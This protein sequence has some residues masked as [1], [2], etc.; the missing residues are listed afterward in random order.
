MKLARALL[1][2][3]VT[4]IGSLPIPAQTLWQDTTFGMPI[5]AV[6]LAVPGAESPQGKPNTLNGGAVEL[7]RLDNVSILSRRW[8]ASFFFLDSK[9]VQVNLTTDD[10]SLQKDTIGFVYR[11][12]LDTLR[13]KYGRELSARNDRGLGIDQASASW[14]SNGTNINA[15]LFASPNYSS[16]NIAYQVRM[17]KDAGKL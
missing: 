2:A 15:S 4:L 12:L 9:L 8:A 17:S 11:D 5:D 3:T 7:L 6:R 16:I 1:I 10:P 13:A 14:F